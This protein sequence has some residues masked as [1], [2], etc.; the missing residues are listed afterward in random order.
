MAKILGF[1]LLL[2]LVFLIV[3]VALLNPSTAVDIDLFFGKFV[4]V[5]LVLALFLA[6]LL[7]S[8]MAFL[9]LAGG[10]IKLRLRIR[11]LGGRIREYEQELTAIRNIPIE[12]SGARV[13]ED[14]S[15]AP[16]GTS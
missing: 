11:Q 12:G 8:L 15:A 2:V 13:V 6:F 3:A 10:A 9:Y 5:P 4:D 1:I 7:G 14:T 16:P